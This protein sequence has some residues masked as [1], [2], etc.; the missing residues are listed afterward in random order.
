MPTLRRANRAWFLPALF[1]TAAAALPGAASLGAAEPA[2]AEPAA[3]ADDARLAAFFRDHLDRSFRL[4]PLEASSLGDHR[5][6]A[7]LDDIS[8]EA[9]ERWVEAW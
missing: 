2:A 5:F 4:R 6:D 3:G 9:R 8:P 7:L 1:V